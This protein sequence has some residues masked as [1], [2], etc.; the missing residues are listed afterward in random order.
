[1]RARGVI[2]F[3]AALLLTACPKTE[4][5]PGDEATVQE[6]VDDGSDLS[7][8]RKA[9]KK[10]RTHK[11]TKVSGLPT[12]AEGQAAL[13]EGQQLIE[14]ADFRAAEG[15]LRIAAAAG[16]DGSDALL[17]RVRREIAAEDAIVAAQKKI[18]DKDYAGARADLRRVV[19]GLVLTDLAKQ[20]TSKLDQRDAD[21]R[22]E[23][24][25]KVAG[26][27]E[28]DASMPDA[29]PSAPDAQAEPPR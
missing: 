14:E 7:E 22:K 4:R 26:R 1:M 18:A 15:E 29:A 6:P 3:T 13:T 21:A 8:F 17:L 11:K 28:A 2:G 24:Q 25:A 5:P 12:R 9:R 27:F 23:L 16:I 20:M 10:G 19:G